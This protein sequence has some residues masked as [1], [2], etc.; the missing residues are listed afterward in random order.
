MKCSV[1]HF[2]ADISIAF[3]LIHGIISIWQSSQGIIHC[4][5]CS[6]CCLTKPDTII[7]TTAI[8]IL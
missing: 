8:G 7:Y 4:C 5:H 1:E 2:L 6:A 3:Q